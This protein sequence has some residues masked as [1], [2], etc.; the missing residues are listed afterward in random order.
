MTAPATIHLVAAEESGDV[1]GAA[2]MRALRAI[3]PEIRFAGVGGRN[4]AREGIVSPFPVEELAIVGIGAIARKLP[5]ILARIRETAGAVV[6]ARPDALVIIDS[7]DFTHR[8]ARKVRAAAPDIPIINYAPPTVWAWRPWRARAMRAYV[9]EVLAILPF[10]PAAYLRLDGPHCTY[11]G[12]PLAERIAALRPN[13][14]EAHRRRADPPVVLVLPG[15]RNSEISRLL[16]PFGAAIA[17]A[18]G[19]AGPFELI[20]PTV[21]HVAERVRRETA[22]WSMRPRILVDQSEKDAAFRIAR[23]ALAASGTVTLELALAQIPMAAAYRIAVWEG[24]IFR[25]LALID[26]ANLANLVIGE[27]VVPEYLQSD[28]R[29]DALATGLLPLI[30]DTPQRQSQLEAFGRLDAIMAL[31]GDAPSR[32]AAQAVLRLVD[33]SA[34]AASLSSA[35][36]SC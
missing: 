4:M 22:G 29:A 30:A 33:R 35:A 27:K 5:R 24:W 11:V 12:H 10:E 3:R 25:L 31:G 16:A 1:L 13:A 23:A 34:P 7:P 18:A 15:S 20:L 26:T 36:G 17:Q 28:C 14:E 32:R 8:V 19:K 21:P 9:D 6:A 2:L